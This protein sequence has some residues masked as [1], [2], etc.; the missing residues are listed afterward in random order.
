MVVLPEVEEGS[1]WRR[2]ELRRH[3]CRLERERVSKRVKRKSGALIF[4]LKFS[5]LT[6]LGG[7]ETV[8]GVISGFHYVFGPISVYFGKG[9]GEISVGLKASFRFFVM[10]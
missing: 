10:N 9:R 4:G 1:A 7:I 3:C 6:G 5:K 2:A 8:R